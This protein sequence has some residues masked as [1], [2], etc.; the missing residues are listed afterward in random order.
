[1]GKSPLTKFGFYCWVVVPHPSASS[2]M[3]PYFTDCGEGPGDEEEGQLGQVESV[4][5]L[6]GGCPLV[7][8]VSVPEGE[9]AQGPI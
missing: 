6:R 1:M 8:V 4:L 9:P 7:L 5:C 3:E 2:N